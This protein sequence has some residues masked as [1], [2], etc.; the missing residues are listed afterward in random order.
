VKLSPPASCTNSKCLIMVTAVMLVRK[1]LQTLGICRCEEET[2]GIKAQDETKHLSSPLFRL[3]RCGCSC[4][5]IFR[6]GVFESVET[7]RDE[8]SA[9]F[10]GCSQWACRWSARNM[11][12]AHDLEINC[13]GTVHS[14]CMRD[15]QLVQ[16]SC[17]EQYMPCNVR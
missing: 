3:C 8:I 5:L 6:C 12:S 7:K 14:A 1:R 2:N 16:E 10:H 15:G 11:F 13:S 17:T 4:R 9:S